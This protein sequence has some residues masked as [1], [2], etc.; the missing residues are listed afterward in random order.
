MAHAVEIGQNGEQAF[1]SFREP[2]WHNLG[3]VFTEE[4]ST[5]EMLEAAYLHNWNVRLEAV[6]YPASYNVISPSYMVV[7]TNPADAGNDI[8]ATVGERYRVYQ[9]EELFSFADNLTD[10]GARW[11]S[12]GSIKRGRQVFGSLE[13]DREMVIDPQGI[14]DKSNSI[15]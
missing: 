11:E 5:R 13:I 4:K 15:C 14:S 9:N 2:A 6:P 10:G 12:A 8:L 3:T 1:A 7:R